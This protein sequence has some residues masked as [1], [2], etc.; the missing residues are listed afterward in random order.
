MFFAVYQGLL[1]CLVHKAFN[2]YL[3]IEWCVYISH[4]VVIYLQ[5]CILHY[6]GS[7]SS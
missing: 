7:T 6:I 3:L 5:V 4:S 2:K 1:W